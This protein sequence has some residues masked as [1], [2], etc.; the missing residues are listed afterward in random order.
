MKIAQAIKAGMIAADPAP[1]RAKISLT[2]HR[3][4]APALGLWGAACGALCVIVLPQSLAYA[5]GAKLLPFVPFA[6]A[7]PALAVGAAI[8]MAAL[9]YALARMVASGGRQRHAGDDLQPINAAQDLGSESLDAPLSEN[10]GDQAALADVYDLEYDLAEFAAL[11]GRDAVWVAEAPGEPVA[12]P[13]ADVGGAFSE[14]SDADVSAAIAK[15]RAV[16][17]AELSLC[18]MV[19]R[20]AAALREY[21][22]AQ[23][24]EPAQQTREQRDAVLGEALK[25]LDIVTR[26]GNAQ[27]QASQGAAMPPPAEPSQ[28]RGAAA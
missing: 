11:P 26:K 8:A 17:P 2:T 21:Q 20:F 5:I 24:S 18:E 10:F 7:K 3:M 19:E 13:A 15:L 25:A 12:P 23:E 6:W 4:F 27:I 16:P 28:A 14:A 22:S 1:R 9:C